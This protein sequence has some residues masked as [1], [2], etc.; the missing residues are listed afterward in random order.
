M[1]RSTRVI[2]LFIFRLLP[3]SSL[4]RFPFLP[5]FF[6][7][8]GLFFFF[9][10]SCPSC[11]CCWRSRTS[12]LARSSSAASRV[13]RSSNAA[14][15]SRCR[16]RTRFDPLLPW[17]SAAAL[18]RAPQCPQ[19]ACFDPISNGAPQAPQE[20]R[21]GP[22]VPTAGPGTDGPASARACD[23]RAV[24]LERVRC[25]AATAP[26]ALATAPAPA[27]AVEP[28]RRAS[29]DR[30]S[31][32]TLC[33]CPTRRDDRAAGRFSGVSSSVAAARPAGALCVPGGAAADEG[34]S[35]GSF[36]SSSEWEDVVHEVQEEEDPEEEEDDEPLPW[37][38]PFFFFF[39][40]FLLLLLPFSFVSRFPVS[41]LLAGGTASCDAVRS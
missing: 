9:F 7:L 12:A 3:C 18:R 38:F 21:G 30:C 14:A 1:C 33:A 6:F 23:V 11:G 25:T 29:S 37:V 15:S 13:R 10:A 24:S 17:R 40:F 5:F 19:N 8:E 20:S 28:R 35:V 32:G 39:F 26:A 41:W 31:I 36:P 16:R 2:F 22:C 34:A 4:P 27:P